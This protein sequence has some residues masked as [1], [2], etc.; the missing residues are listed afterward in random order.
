MKSPRIKLATHSWW[1]YSSPA[2]LS[3]HLTNFLTVFLLDDTGAHGHTAVMGVL[4]DLA[5]RRLS[6]AAPLPHLVS[7]R[8]RAAAAVEAV[9]GVAQCKQ[10]RRAT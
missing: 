8:L 2:E 6:L 5:G 7:P 4:A 3:S 10:P 9:A 1:S